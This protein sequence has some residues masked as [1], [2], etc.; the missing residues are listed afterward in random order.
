MRTTLDIEDDVLAAAKEL[1]RRQHRSAGA[2]VSELARR[3]LTLAAGADEAGQGGEAFLG[4]RPFARR[5]DVVV[6]NTLIDKLRD[7]GAY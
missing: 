4:F 2:V 3:G 5:S 7:E 1:A 6:T